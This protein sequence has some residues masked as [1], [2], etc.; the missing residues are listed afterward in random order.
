VNAL[1]RLGRR[2][3]GVLEDA[4]NLTQLARESAAFMVR[5]RIRPAE[6][7]AQAYFL[8]VQS[9]SIV[10]LTS[11]FVGMVFSL[12]SAVSAV[13][14]GLAFIVGGVVA[15]TSS[16]ELG[17]LLTAVVVAGRA[18]AAIA[19]EIGSMVVTEQVE[20]LEALGLPPVRMLVVPRLV[21]L[22]VMLPM[23]TVL[24]DVISIAGGMI[25][26]LVI[27]QIDFGTFLDSARQVVGLD[28]FAKGVAKSFVF[29]VIIVLVGS[30]R[31]LR[32]KGGAAG[33][34][35][36]TTQAVV[37]SIILIFIANFLLS[38]VLFGNA[39]K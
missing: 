18:G 3:T 6:T 28:D 35:K 23:L 22:L 9:T 30:D 1:V 25:S 31:G 10:L 17:P 20:A 7:I 39:T 5:A 37:V 21:A 12:E 24:A 15:Y 4:G 29:A 16:R 19:A 38:V 11:L 33:V 32:T 36:S 13:Q 14:H 34:G 27:A 2:T 8:G 26:A